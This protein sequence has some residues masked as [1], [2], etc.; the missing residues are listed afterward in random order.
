M[1]DA[2]KKLEAKKKD[3]NA[4]PDNYINKD[5]IMAGAIIHGTEV[6]PHLSSK[7]S[8]ADLSCAL[9]EIEYHYFVMRLNA[10]ARRA[11]KEKQNNRIINPGGNGRM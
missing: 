9:K 3:F 1:G 5:D 4:N 11:M 10:E 8:M 7:C 2:K 6:R